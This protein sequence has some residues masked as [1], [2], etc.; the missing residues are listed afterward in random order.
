MAVDQ[1]STL[2]AEIRELIYE[3]HIKK[4]KL[5]AGNSKTTTSATSLLLVSQLIYGEFVIIVSNYTKFKVSVYS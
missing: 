3:H 4:T 5:C 1:F 2:P